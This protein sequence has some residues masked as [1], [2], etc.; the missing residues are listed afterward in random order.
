MFLITKGCHPLKEDT[1]HSR[2]SRKNL[3]ADIEESLEELHTDHVDLWF[4]HRDKPEAPADELIDMANEEVYEKGYARY[5]GASTG[6]ANES[7]RPMH[8]RR[9]MG[10]R[11]LQ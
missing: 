1:H 9:H 8:G 2:I 10:S 11:D 6:R 3:I 7:K 4:F 5:L